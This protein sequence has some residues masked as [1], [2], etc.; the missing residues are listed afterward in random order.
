M[1]EVDKLLTIKKKRT[2]KEK[3]KIRL[4]IDEGLVLIDDSIEPYI[5]EF[6]RKIADK[7]DLEEFSYKFHFIYRIKVKW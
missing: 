1:S 2:K 3:K 6:L 5:A 4:E 7:Y